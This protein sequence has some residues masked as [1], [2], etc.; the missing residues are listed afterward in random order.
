LDKA[1]NKHALEIEINTSMKYY[2][3]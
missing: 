1:Y 3:N 2:H